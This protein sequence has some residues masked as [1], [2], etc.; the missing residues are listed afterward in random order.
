MEPSRATTKDVLQLHCILYLKTSNHLILTA[1]STPRVTEPDHDSTRVT[2]QDRV[3]SAKT[4]GYDD[5]RTLHSYSLAVLVSAINMEGQTK[6]TEL[7]LLTPTLN[8]GVHNIGDD[9]EI[10][11]PLPP[12]SM[13]ALKERIK[14]HYEICSDYYYS[15]W[16]FSPMPTFSVD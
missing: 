9:Y 16:Y 1:I 11:A 5:F 14:Y 10:P 3:L 8:N 2:R 12:P 15:L 4:S 7:S 6:A 13:S